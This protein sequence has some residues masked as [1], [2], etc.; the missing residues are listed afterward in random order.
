MGVWWTGTHIA[1]LWAS[2]SL[3]NYYEPS[4]LLLRHALNFAQDRWGGLLNMKQ[5]Q[6]F[7]LLLTAAAYVDNVISVAQEA[8]YQAKNGHQQLAGKKG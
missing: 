8:G 3:S 6:A 5:N 2:Q 1:P 7:P 4:Q